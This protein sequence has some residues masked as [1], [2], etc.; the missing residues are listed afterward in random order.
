M[1]GPSLLGQSGDRRCCGTSV[2]GKPSRAGQSGDTKQPM[3]RSAKLL[4]WEGHS[5]QQAD[6]KAGSRELLAEGPESTVTAT[7]TLLCLPFAPLGAILAGVGVQLRRCRNRYPAPHSQTETLASAPLKLLQGGASSRAQLA[8]S[9]PRRHQ[10][11]R[12]ERGLS[13][14]RS[15][16][17]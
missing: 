13:R 5:V 10:G 7:W 1:A 14:I 17:L 9:A 8:S 11:Q 6:S 16:Q 2:L 15:E 12:G 3:A 4:V